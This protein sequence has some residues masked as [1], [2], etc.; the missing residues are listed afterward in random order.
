M[1]QCSGD[2]CMTVFGHLDARSQL[3]MAC[4]S[5]QWRDLPHGRHTRQR[6]RLA[7]SMDA[8]RPPATCAVQQ[9]GGAPLTRITLHFATLSRDAY[10]AC[11]YAFVPYC[12]VHHQVYIDNMSYGDALVSGVNDVDICVLCLR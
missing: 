4:V 5:R 8:R 2:I 11:Q 6:A 1:E 7:I 12:R 10:R 3:R 9:C